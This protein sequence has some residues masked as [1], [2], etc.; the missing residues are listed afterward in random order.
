MRSIVIAILFAVCL[1]TLGC[2]RT[3]EEKAGKFLRDGTGF[4]SRQDYP[5]AILS[6][7]NAAKTLPGK[8][9]PVYQLGLA[10]LAAGNLN[11]GIA[12]IFRAT[13]LDPKHL[14]AQAKLAELMAQSGDK[15][16]AQSGKKRMQGVLETAP[17]N[18]DALN[19]LA[20]DELALGD[21]QDAE[22]HLKDALQR[23]PSNL[24]SSINLALVYLSKREASK[25]EEVLRVLRSS[26][27]HSP[28]V[29][30]A[31]AEFY[32]LTGRWAEA[33]KE[34]QALI[35]LPS[36]ANDPRALTGLAAAALRLGKK[37]EAEQIYLR[38]SKLPDKRY[39]HFYAAYLFAE[40][41]RDQSIKEL[42]RIVESDPNDRANRSR[43][44]TAYILVGQPSA[45]QKLIESA[46]KANPHDA[47]ALMQHS[48]ILLRSG[49]VTEAE[50]D[51]N[52]VLHFKPDSPQ[53][54]FLLAQVRSSQGNGELINSELNQ[55][56]SY[57]AAFLPARL[58]LA[59]RLTVAKS[60]NAAL[61]L[62]DSAPEAQKS[63]LSIALQRNLANF[64]AGNKQAFRDGV[65]RAL[66]AA[67]TRDVLLQDAIAKLMDR[68]FQA[69]D[70]VIEEAL[71]QDPESV[72]AV[73]AKALSYSAQNRVAEAAKFL[74]AQG[75]Q[76]RS[77][78]VSEFA[79]EWLWSEGDHQG[80]RA[81][82]AH[83]RS[84]DPGYVPASLALAQIDAKDGHA[85]KARAGLEEVVRANPRNL[86]AR[87]QLASLAETAGDRTGAEEQYRKALEIQPRYSPAL[88]NLAYVLAEKA[89]SLDEALTYAQQAVE[90]APGN[91]DFAGTLGWV[92]Y[93]KGLYRNALSLLQQAVAADGQ[94]GQAN[95][96]VRKYHLGMTYLNLGEREQGTQII[97]AALRQ[98]PKL[99]EAA[100]A[101]RLI[102]SR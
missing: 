16:L 18:I 94:S 3:P 34:F 70:A 22:R 27:P 32:M 45:A 49:K 87:L 99:P 13:R 82:F 4:M 36:F 12:A 8:A 59:Q 20:L 79:G 55:S 38:L 1:G 21:Y 14:R 41:R 66:A 63:S 26:A 102:N 97:S 9:E 28:D 91:P 53:A 85:D 81:A 98:N 72:R 40:G 30:V 67:R 42:R 65:D 57:D 78:R 62:L 19:A 47:D 100:V 44:V 7:E 33:E 71:R 29:T 64:V 76:T 61:Q 48:Q 69:A 39:K 17:D 15:N 46:L 37:E 58:E 2:R 83:A 31:F 90:G 73:Q 74:S 96:V 6:F 25:A 92:F 52:E 50:S 68:N 56:L 101:T 77:V 86:Q 80:A 35:G 43:L 5:R 23:L 24:T 88:N 89:D 11:A 51:L 75:S 95:A 93:R 60:P 10:Y 84:M 54:H